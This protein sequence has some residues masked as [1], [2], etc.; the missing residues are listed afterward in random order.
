M[1]YLL[2]RRVHGPGV[3][4]EVSA[5]APSVDWR[6]A[7]ELARDLR[8]FPLFAR[9][10]EIVT[11]ERLPQAVRQEWR[12]LYRAMT[13][14]TLLLVAENRRLLASMQAAG[15]EALPV[16]GPTLAEQLYGQA[17]LRDYDDLDYVVA[18][19]QVAAA[20]RV[21]ESCGYECAESPARQ[22]RLLRSRDWFAREF[23]Y[24]RRVADV[25]VTVELHWD[26]FPEAELSLMGAQPED[27]A[28]YLAQHGG[29]HL[30]TPVRFLCDL[31]DWIE[32]HQSTFDWQRLAGHAGAQRLRRLTAAALVLQRE[33]LAGVEVPAVARAQ[34]GAVD[35]GLLQRLKR[36]I[37]RNVEPQADLLEFH[38]CRAALLD[39]AAMRGAYWWRLLAP[40][41][42]E[43][44]GL[45]PGAEGRAWIRRGRRLA[46]RLAHSFRLGPSS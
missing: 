30:W 22:E 26:V 10:A 32:A 23:T 15:V 24:T 38:R 11:G 19:E 33:M 16:K 31:R 28:L 25:D 2:A 13:A 4:G 46:G 9:G 7:G 41:A 40:T 1:V 34:F 3:C 12:A 45:P 42:T 18:R 21:V 20:G 8:L 14:R 37:E 35:A 17:A 6:K 27:E 39:T 44:D 36:R 43:R 29:R 5:A